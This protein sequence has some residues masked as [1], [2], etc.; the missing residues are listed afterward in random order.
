MSRSPPPSGRTWSGAAPAK[1]N[2]FLRIL[3]REEGGY[4]QIETL[5]QAL[6]LSDRVKLRVSEAEVRPREG[7]RPAGEG[8]GAVTLSVEGVEEGALGSPDSNL[9]VRAARAFLDEA[10]LDG[11][12]GPPSVAI[13][14]EKHIPHG[15]GL[16][17]G[18]SDAAAVLRG[19]GDLFPDALAPER[20]HA[21]AGELGTDVPFFLGGGPLALG[22]GRGDRLLR[23]PPLPSRRVVLLIPEAPIA[24]PWAYQ[25]LAAHRDARGEGAAPARVLGPELLEPRTGEVGRNPRGT[26]DDGTGGPSHSRWDRV[27]A[28][29][30]NAFQVAL[31]PHRPEL[32]HLRRGLA[33]AG[34]APALLSGSGSSLFG[35]FASPSEAERA[36]AELAHRFPGVRR[37]R[38]RTLVAP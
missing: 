29:A 19:L 21:L 31:E 7:A 27:A 18:S 3:A 13:H 25:V 24:T 15:A 16:G 36:E 28:S 2:L 5:F 37:I 11:P 32:G 35:I 38:T 1:V 20:L 22:W 33:A 30:E 17:G 12:G 6:E 26:E 9:A 23:L 34:A 4:H 8:A 14:L 10:R